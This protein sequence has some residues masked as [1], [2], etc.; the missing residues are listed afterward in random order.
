MINLS[1]SMVYNL[2]V[3]WHSNYLNKYR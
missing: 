1:M 2:C 3:Y